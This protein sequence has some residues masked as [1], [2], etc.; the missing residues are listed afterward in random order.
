[1]THTPL[2][3]KADVIRRLLEL[4]GRVMV[5]LDATQKGVDV[6]R[7]FGHDAG[8]MLV[9]NRSMPQPIHIRP[10]AVVSELRFGGIPHYCVLPYTAI[11]SVF[12]PDTNHGMVWPDDMPE[13]VYD[14]YA[15]L[16]LTLDGVL[17]EQAQY[18]QMGFEAEEA[19]P[20][21]PPTLPDKKSLPVLTV[22]DGGQATPSSEHPIPSKATKAR[23]PVLRLVE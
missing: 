10:D 13:H 19:H 17:P 7:R 1:M 6:P 11:W 3:E 2:P 21:I 4:E 15:A 18:A 14:T 20:P 12:N 5:C 8:L 16:P 23:K 22:I 9:L